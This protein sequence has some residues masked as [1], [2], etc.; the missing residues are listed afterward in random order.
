MKIRLLV[1]LILLTILSGCNSNKI[2]KTLME[3]APKYYSHIAAY[4]SGTIS[5][6]A[7]ISIQLRK[8]ITELPNDVL[9]FSPSIKGNLSL[10]KDSMT[11]I[12][13][14]TEKLKSGTLYTGNLNL[15][16]LGQDISKELNEFKF[17]FE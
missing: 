8:K 10:D 5:K 3:I 17:Q 1:S 9:D 13:T 14:P 2:D 16:K 12:F 7:P 15:K 4:T 11:L 6:S